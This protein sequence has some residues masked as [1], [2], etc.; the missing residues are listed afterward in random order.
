MR[1]MPNEIYHVYNRGNNSQRIFITK[2]N[3]QFFLG[4]IRKSL[5]SDCD[6]IAYCLMPNHFH[7][8]LQAK[9]QG[10]KVEGEDPMSVQS[11]TRKIGLLQSS[12]ARAIQKQE[13]ITGSLFQQKTKA[14]LIQT[15]AAPR[16]NAVAICLHYIHQNPLKAG[17]VG[18]LED[19]E[20][21]SYRDYMGYRKDIL[22]NVA[23]GLELCGLDETTF[24]NDSNAVMRDEIIEKV[25]Y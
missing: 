20:L 25:M 6:I 5:L 11:L 8:L 16:S 22:C 19:W 21:S 13:G 17:L 2:A 4:K 14:K 15:N 24:S 10:C 3:Y 23:L 7:L 1:F 12:Y 18:R 9:E